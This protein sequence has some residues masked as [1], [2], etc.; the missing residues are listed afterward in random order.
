MK[1][2][3]ME[4]RLTACFSSFLGSVYD[5]AANSQLFIQFPAAQRKEIFQSEDA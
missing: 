1:K 4:N 3:R 5:I 2:E